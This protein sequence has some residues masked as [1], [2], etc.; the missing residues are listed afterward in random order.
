[1]RSSSPD[2]I[3]ARRLFA[4][5][6]RRFAAR[7]W[8]GVSGGELP[9]STGF[10]RS[11]AA[12]LAGTLAV[13]G[14]WAS[15][16]PGSCAYRGALCWCPWRRPRAQMG[17]GARRSSC[18]VASRDELCRRRLEHRRA[19]SLRDT[20]AR[21][22]RPAAVLAS[23]LA[24]IAICGGFAV[25][26]PLR[27]RRRTVDRLSCHQPRR[28]RYGR[29]HRRLEQGRSAFRY[30]DADDALRPR[31]S[32]RPVP[33]AARRGLDEPGASVSRR[34]ERILRGLCARAI[35]RRISLP[36][37]E[38]RIRDGVVF[39]FGSIRQRFVSRRYASPLRP[40]DQRPSVPEPVRFASLAS[41]NCRR[42]SMFCW[43]FANIAVGF[44]LLRSFEPQGP[45]A[46]AGWTAVGVGVLL[47]GVL[48]S[49]HFGRV[50]GNLR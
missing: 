40:G 24:L 27:G 34:G 28:R 43:G 2:A 37:R 26:F 11:L 6:P 32:G 48:L 31:L 4:A 42:S 5:S 38:R 23:I 39:L 50:R 22:A 9:P 15:R 35:G 30:G 16:R 25:D 29:H 14:W 18:P 10:R 36:D 44:A 47:A 17:L 19:A 8:A 13:A 20:A 49:R 45:E 41:G 21:L 12:P 33:G 3:S 7:L 46:V 1:M